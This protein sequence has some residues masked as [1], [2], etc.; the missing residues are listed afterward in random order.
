MK[1]GENYWNILVFGNDFRGVFSYNN[2]MRLR[3]FFSKIGK[4]I[5][6]KI[7][8]KKATYSNS[9]LWIEKKYAIDLIPVKSYMKCFVFLVT[10]TLIPKAS[11]GV[12]TI[13][14][15]I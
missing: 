12:F 11:K 9:S 14:Y 4:K 10:T 8:G 3:E 13:A 1:W 2:W 5:T 6:P 15:L 7:R